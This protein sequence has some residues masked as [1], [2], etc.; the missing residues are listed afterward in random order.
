MPDKKHKLA[1]IVFTDIVGYTKRMEENEQKTMQLLQQQ[2][3]IVF[4]MVESYGGEVIKELGDG[5]L[6]MFTSAVQAVRFAISVQTR[7]KDEELTIRAGIHIGDVIFEDGDVFG[8][9]VNTAARIEPMAPANGICIS[10]DVKSQLRNKSDITTISLGKR[11]LKGVSQPVEIFE[12]YVEGISGQQKK[13]AKWFFNDIWKRKVVH[14]IIGYLISAWIIKQAVAAISS[15]YLLSPHLVDLAWVVLL[16]LLPAVFLLSYYHNKRRQEGWTKVELFGLPAN[17]AMT[18]LLVVL[19]FQGKSLGATAQSVTVENE[20]G[21]RI[22]RTIVKSEFRKSLALFNITNISGDSTWDWLQYS[23]PTMIEYDLS[24]DIYINS[25]SA[26]RFFKKLEEAGYE[27]GI[28]LPVSLMSN[29]SEYYHL[30]Y[31]LSGDFSI[32]GGVYSIN[33]KLYDTKTTKL[34]IEN[35]FTGED[36]FKLID[37]IS[38]Q[39]KDDVEIPGYHIDETRDLPIA[40]IFTGSEIAL[41]LYAFAN[42]EILR[43]DYVKGIEYLNQAVEEDPGF[44]IAY[45]SL[46]NFYFSSN[47][48]EKSMETLELAMDKKN[49]DKLPETVQFFVKFFYYLVKQEPDKADAVVKMWVELYPEDT[50]G[51][52]MLAGRYINKG[53]SAEAI[54]QYKKILELDPEEYNYLRSIGDLYEK[55]GNYDSALIYYKLYADKFP[56]DFKSFRE[57]GDLYI[58]LGDFDKAEQNYDRA[59][60]IESS[61]VSIMIRLARIKVLRGD[62][63]DALIEFNNILA[64]SKTAEDSSSVFHALHQFYGLKGQNRTAL[65]YHEKRMNL[66]N[67]FKSPK[68]ILVYQAFTIGY[69]IVAGQEDR[70]FKILEDMEN[71]FESPLDKIAS[72]GYLFAYIELKDTEKAMQEIE[73][74]EALIEGFGEDLLLANIHYANGRINEITENYSEAITYYQQ[75]LDMQPSNMDTHRWIA[76]C[77]RKLGEFKDAEEHIRIPLD[78]DPFNPKN[79]YETGLLYLESGEEK[80][81]REYLQIAN[82]IWTDADPGYE[83]AEDVKEKLAELGEV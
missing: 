46:A 44:A 29:L 68:D 82:D 71:K 8:S 72:F 77:Y 69:Y 2:R 31:F 3:E 56:S 36:I 57:I 61:K 70:A 22:E 25:Q 41:R 9:A 75:F 59:L 42:R 11:E 23:I 64:S 33:T 14:V 45:L 50:E 52:T 1:A 20:D 40:D 12:V 78:L 27:D 13:D 7:L 54:V 81:A 4:P 80:K 67:R 48:A 16:S 15:E 76:R 38:I 24:Q 32:E 37:E 26:V 60:L 47:Q 83:P 51:R 34:L 30:N 17:A 63:E 66:W 73:Q 6:M 39:V 53:Q 19:M 74:A 58:R 43:N 79:N 49:L 10:E 35:N 55:A 21:D 18:L 5:L 65:D 62:F 28:G